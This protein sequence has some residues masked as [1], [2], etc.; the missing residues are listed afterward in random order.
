[1]DSL[2]IV[3]LNCSKVNMHNSGK[4]IAEIFGN[5][6]AGGLTLFTCYELLQYGLAIPTD[7][8]SLL[9]PG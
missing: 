3:K 4:S 5:L 1:M 8:L 7:G 2:Q 6:G 9:L